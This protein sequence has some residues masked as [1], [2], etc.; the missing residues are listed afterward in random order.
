MDPCMVEHWTHGTHLNRDGSQ[1]STVVAW[2]IP[3]YRVYPRIPWFIIIIFRHTYLKF[4][5]TATTAKIKQPKTKEFL[6]TQFS[7]FA[8]IVWSGTKCGMLQP[9]PSRAS[10]QINHRRIKNICWQ[11]ANRI[12][13]DSPE[14]QQYTQGV[15][16]LASS[17]SEVVNQAS[18]I[19]LIHLYKQSP[20]KPGDGVSRGGRTY[21]NKGEPI[22]TA[23]DRLAGTAIDCVISEKF[24]SLTFLNSR[25]LCLMMPQ[26]LDP[27]CFWH[28]WIL[29]A[30]LVDSSGARG[31]THSSLLTNFSWC[32]RCLLKPMS[33]QPLSLSL[34]FSL[35]TSHSLDTVF[36]WHRF[37]CF[38]LFHLLFWDLFLSNL[39]HLTPPVLASRLSWGH[40]FLFTFS[41]PANK[42]HPV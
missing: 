34:S 24:F 12:S 6:D 42:I 25:H 33:L 5:R 9:T 10:L 37:S 11:L 14:F 18:F 1:C 35:S 38:L 41:Y 29:T 2:L 7:L 26:S 27:A 23:A 16:F 36:A 21:K 8:L 15:Y 4:P 19:T 3:Q 31:L 39:F 40:L 22:G 30:L 28:V 20:S 32:H 17:I 13:M